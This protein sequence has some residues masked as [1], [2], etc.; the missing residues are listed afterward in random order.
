MNDKRAR[1]ASRDL[2]AERE[3]RRTGKDRRRPFLKTLG[4]EDDETAELRE[5]NRALTMR[6]GQLNATI[7]R[8]GAELQRTITTDAARVARAASTAAMA[9]LPLTLELCSMLPAIH[10]ATAPI[11]D[12]LKSPRARTAMTRENI[13][14][15]GVLLERLNGRPQEILSLQGV[16]ATTVTE[17][18]NDLRTHAL[19][20]VA[21]ELSIYKARARELEER[22]AE[23]NRH[24]REAERSRPSAWKD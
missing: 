21:S 16:G 13:K 22:L 15:L 17:I 1:Y 12:I 5:Q 10:A 23:T 20:G 4:G 14:T 11:A 18:E 24:R 8:Q 7:R 9:R 2:I 3:Q 19:E 6:V